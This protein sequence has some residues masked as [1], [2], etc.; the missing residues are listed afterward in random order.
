MASLRFL[1]AG[2]SH[3]PGLTVVLE[4]LP[5]GLRVPAEDI[6]LELAR[7][8]M[9]YGRGGRMAIERDR[10]EI[11]AG[12]RHGRTLGGPIALWI[13]NRDFAN[14]SESMSP[15]PR[16][17][18]DLRPLHRP[19]P[20]H[21]DLAGAGKLETDDARPVLERAS[22]RETA[23]RVA[24][25][26]LAKRLLG[27]VGCE[28][29]SH[30]LTL[31]AIRGP[32]AGAVG[33][34]EILAIP[35]DSPFRCVSSEIEQL[36]RAE[37][38]RAREAGDTLGGSFE[39]VAHTP[40]P[41]LGHFSQWDLRLD[42]RVGQAMLSIPA[43]KSVA[44][45]AGERAPDLPGSQVH[46]AIR[47]G[48]SGVER[49]TNRAGGIEGG[50]SNGEEVRVVVGMKPLSTLRQPLESVDLITGNAAPAGFERSDVTVVPAAGVVGEAMLALVL[51]GALLEKFS[52]DS[53]GETLRNVRGH[54]EA[55]GWRGR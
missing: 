44:I 14:W 38:D 34:P 7:R 49:P 8:Q 39:V 32:D 30:T 10:V 12:I 1:T 36:M 16:A 50:M 55:I 13:E 5:A 4:G 20:G 51:A 3:G 54:G 43:A 40:P 26:A 48:P 31:G 25:G 23:A 11:R 27:E 41:G 33:W 24:A 19:R 15:A 46:D 2:E 29:R 35:A 47:R 42:G 9:G 45:G 37:V 22:A 18:A 6:D 52:G 21:A 53:L 17:G 28:V